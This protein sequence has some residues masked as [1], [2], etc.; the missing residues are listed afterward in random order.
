MTTD[1]YFVDKNYFT[2]WT[3][4]LA[5][6]PILMNSDYDRKW[7]R[8]QKFLFFPFPLIS[9]KNCVPLVYLS[10][11]TRGPFS[12]ILFVACPPTS[13][14]VSI[15]NHFTFLST[16]P[17]SFQLG[18]NHPWIQDFTFL[19]TKGLPPLNLKEKQQQLP[20]KSSFF[21]QMPVMHMYIK[22]SGE[23]VHWGS[24]AMYMYICLLKKYPGDCFVKM[25]KRIE[26]KIYPV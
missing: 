17:I 13:F 22:K 15:R 1:T 8:I 26:Y 9:S 14:F 25:Y 23:E 5:E 12:L 10:W 21:T 19:Q 2:H 11:S 6:T 4:P 20:Y 18:T 24:I 3:W 16:C 7:F